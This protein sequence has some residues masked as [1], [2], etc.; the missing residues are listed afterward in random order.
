MNVASL[1]EFIASKYFQPRFK[2]EGQEIVA[3]HTN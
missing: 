1:N 3:V 2:I